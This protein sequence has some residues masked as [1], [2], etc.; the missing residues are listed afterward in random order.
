MIYLNIGYNFDFS[1]LEK[2]KAL[3]EK[4]Q[5]NDIRIYQLYGSLR[6]S[7]I[8]NLV[9]SARPDFRIP[10][11]TLT[12]FQNIHIPEIHEKGFQFNYVMNSPNPAFWLNH[13]DAVYEWIIRFIKKSEI[14]MITIASPVLLAKMIEPKDFP[15]E[16]STIM[17]IRD[18]NAIQKYFSMNNISKICLSIERNR[19]ISFLRKASKF[20]IELL[21]NEFCSY[22]GI[23]CQNFFRPSCYLLHTVGGNPTHKHKGFPLEWCSRSRLREP[24]SFLKAKVIYPW[25]LKRYHNETGICFF[26]ISGRTLSTDFIASVAEYYMSLGKV[27]PENMLSLWGHVEEGITF[28][29]GNEPIFISSKALIDCD[30]TK[31]WFS[32]P[33]WRCSENLCSNCVYCYRTFAY[34]NR[35]GNVIIPKKTHRPEEI[36]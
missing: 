2:L 29:A 11:I 23:P 3:N 7:N 6:L 12:D 19:D 36:K 17:E 16:I 26:K 1:L 30:F 28:E 34:M 35:G 13:S 9:G 33:D 10:D 20:P 32:N 25:D 24:V 27:Y 21:V 4:Y 31:K 18:L 5:K 15:I 14:D 22:E 8:G